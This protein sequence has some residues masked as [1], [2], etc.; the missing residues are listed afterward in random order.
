M[1]EDGGGGFLWSVVRM[2]LRVFEEE[3]GVEK[4]L[5]CSSLISVLENKVYS[6]RDEAANYVHLLLLIGPWWSCW[7]L[8]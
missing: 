8:E 1:F 7:K 2:Q 3:Y 6:M 5:I 4:F